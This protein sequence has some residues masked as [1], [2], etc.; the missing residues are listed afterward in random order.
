MRV[1]I[2]IPGPCMACGF[3][4]CSGYISFGTKLHERHCTSCLREWE[5]EMRAVGAIVGGSLTLAYYRQWQRE[6]AQKMGVA[7]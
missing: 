4:R 6:R 2:I 5:S 7:A 3:L 1:K